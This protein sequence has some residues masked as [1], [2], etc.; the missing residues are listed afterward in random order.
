MIKRKIYEIAKDLNKQS[1]DII[2]I[3]KEVSPSEVNRKHNSSILEDDINLVLEYYVSTNQKESLN[4]DGNKQK[5]EQKVGKTNIKKRQIEKF[6]KKQEN[7][8]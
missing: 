7:V 6:E 2:T 8:K 4:V 3:L 5:D 1:K